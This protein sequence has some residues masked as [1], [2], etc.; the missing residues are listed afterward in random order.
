MGDRGNG[1]LAQMVQ[2]QQVLDT[3]KY[4]QEAMIASALEHMK[5]L[6]S[7][8]LVPKYRKIYQPLIVRDNVI[9]RIFNSGKDKFTGVFVLLKS[10]N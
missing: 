2:E 10:E 8:D 6:N 9:I 1:I 3:I 5:A 4:K 7:S